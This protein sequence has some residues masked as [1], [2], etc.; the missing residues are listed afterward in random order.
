[1][2][3]TLRS[4]IRSASSW[5]VI[6]SG[7]ITSRMIFSRTPGWHRHACALH[8]PPHRGEQQRALVLAVE[9]GDD[10]E[11]GAAT[12]VDARRRLDHRRLDAL[13]RLEGALALLL[14][15]HQ[16]RTRRGRRLG[17]LAGRG[18][19]ARAGRRGRPRS[20]GGDEAR[21]RSCDELVLDLAA[22]LLL[23]A[24]DLGAPR[25]RGGCG[26]APRV[27]DGPPPRR[28]G[29]PSPSRSRA[30]AKRLGAGADLFP[31]SAC[32]GRCGPAARRPAVPAGRRR[33]RRRVPSA[34]ASGRASAAAD[35]TR[36]R[37]AAHHRAS[38]GVGAA[39]VSLPASPGSVS[40]RFFFSTTTDFVRP[41]LKLWRT[42]PCL[43]RR[44]PQ[45]QRLPAL[46]VRVLSPGSLVSLM[47]SSVPAR[48]TAAR[49]NP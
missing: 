46:D 20:P 44:P 26:R 11:L 9:R 23:D 36:P 2:T 47:P 40:R 35:G 32:G 6:V 3:S 38:A 8:P 28:A 42:V 25:A 22:G 48:A 29:D 45:G 4:A 12:V 27:R 19:A 41:W 7:R 18:R 1:M 49:S 14:V 10:G 13:R 17:G 15:R 34:S 24:A 39:A 21:P 43:D 30:S 33:A 16:R 5:M 31:A 37:R